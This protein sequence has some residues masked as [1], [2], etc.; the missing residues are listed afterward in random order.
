ME[1][2][3]KTSTLIVKYIYMML[4]LLLTIT[5][6]KLRL[7]NVHENTTDVWNLG[8]SLNLAIKIGCGNWNIIWKWAFELMRQEDKR[9]YDSML[10]Q[11][12]K[13][14]IKAT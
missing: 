1:V 9:L 12:F 4:Y 3:P 5:Q 14:E 7:R 10:K 11:S 8:T 13:R 2:F 6:M